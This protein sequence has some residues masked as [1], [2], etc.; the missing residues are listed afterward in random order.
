MILAFRVDLLD[1]PMGLVTGLDGIG[2]VF[3]TQN[4]VFC[5]ELPH[6]N[7][8][9]LGRDWAGL[10]GSPTPEPKQHSLATAFSLAVFRSIDGE[11]SKQVASE[12]WARRLWKV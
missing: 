4:T 2:F 3:E 11:K 8:M 7:R 6:E 10:V 5:I 12:V 1:I 9:G